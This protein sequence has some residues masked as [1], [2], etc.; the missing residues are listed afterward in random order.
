MGKTKKAT[1]KWVVTDAVRYEVEATSAAAALSKFRKGNPSDFSRMDGWSNAEDW[2]DD[3]K[4]A[5]I[6]DLLNGALDGKFGQVGFN[7]GQNFEE[8]WE[9][10]EGLLRSMGWE[11]GDIRDKYMW[12]DEDGREAENPAD[13]SDD[14][15]MVTLARDCD[16]VYWVEIPKDDATKILTVGVPF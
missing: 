8:W 6:S 12:D 15:I 1:Y 2:W 14:K 4:R 10:S 9:K 7:H 11:T 16:L 3:T 13:S 5:R